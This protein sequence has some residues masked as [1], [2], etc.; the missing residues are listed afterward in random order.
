MEKAWER[1]KFI[2]S[3]KLPKNIGTK[4]ILTNGDAT[5]KEVVQMWVA[6]VEGGNKNMLVERSKFEGKQP[7]K[8]KYGKGV[9]KE[10][11]VTKHYVGITVKHI[12]SKFEEKKTCEFRN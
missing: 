7:W 12:T 9:D 4:I 1:R 11:N 2:K 3:L 6:Y 5:N 8:V 10:V